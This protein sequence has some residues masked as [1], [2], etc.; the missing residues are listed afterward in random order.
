MVTIFRTHGLRFVI[1]T[2]DHEPAHVHVIG[3]GEAK[4][5]LAGSG[6]RPELVWNDGMKRG[7]VRRAMAT[8]EKNLEQFLDRW[9]DMHG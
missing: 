4:I 1:F 6:N 7:D 3:E 5:N 8:V 2:N 9:S